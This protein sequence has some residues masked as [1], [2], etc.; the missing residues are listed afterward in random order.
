MKCNQCGRAVHGRVKDAIRKAAILLCRECM[1]DHLLEKRRR[2]TRPTNE[3]SMKALGLFAAAARSARP[4][5]PPD[6]PAWQDVLEEDLEEPDVVSM[7]TE[8]LDRMAAR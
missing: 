3:L 8:D 1:T 7:S 2:V 6:R 4:Q 5:L